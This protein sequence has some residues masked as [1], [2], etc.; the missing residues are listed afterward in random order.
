MEETP[1]EIERKFFPVL[2]YGYAFEPHTN[3]TRCFASNACINM[4][5]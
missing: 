4:S 2:P 3:S 1:S 5:I